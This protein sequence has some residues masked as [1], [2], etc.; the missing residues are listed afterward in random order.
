MIE[1]KPPP[2]RLMVPLNVMLPVPDGVSVAELLPP[3]TPSTTTR[4]EEGAPMRSMSGR[5]GVAATVVRRS[6]VE[7]VEVHHTPTIAIHAGELGLAWV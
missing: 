6:R 7:A 5:E 3:M 1:A 4:L 2:T